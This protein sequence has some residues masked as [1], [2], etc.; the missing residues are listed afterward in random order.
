L[1]SPRL[2]PLV[3]FWYYTVFLDSFLSFLLRF[4][5]Q[6]L[7]SGLNSTDNLLIHAA[8][9][10]QFYG[11]SGRC[12]SRNFFSPFFCCASAGGLWPLP[13]APVPLLSD[14][15]SRV[16]GFSEFLHLFT[17]VSFFSPGYDFLCVAPALAARLVM[18]F[19]S[20]LK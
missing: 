3:P 12:A 13:S 1:P 8:M 19:R 9:F 5:A 16:V 18:S 7:I 10:F 6:G 14:G 20:H 4:L 17:S 11:L 15:P 2:D